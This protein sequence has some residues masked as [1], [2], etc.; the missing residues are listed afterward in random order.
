MKEI[1]YLWQNR[2][3]NSEFSQK[4]LFA[5]CQGCLVILANFRVIFKFPFENIKIKEKIIG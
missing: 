4:L 2:N 3:N 5:R 1:H